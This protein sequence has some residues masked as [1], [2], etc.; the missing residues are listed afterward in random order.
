VYFDA[1]LNLLNILNNDIDIEQNKDMHYCISNAGLS[2]EIC[3][4][5]N[6]CDLQ[7]TGLLL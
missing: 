2:P 6:M 5:E 7:G 4:G 3:T 1:L